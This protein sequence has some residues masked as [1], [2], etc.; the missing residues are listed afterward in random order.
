MELCA[1]IEGL[2]V[3]KE[4]CAVEIFTDSEY[5]RNGITQWIKGWKA[6][7]WRT[8]DKKPVKNEDLWRE[9]D[10]ACARHRVTWKWLKGHAGHADNERC[11]ELAGKAI[12]TIRQQHSAAD[13]KAALAV[14]KVSPEKDSACL[15]L[16]GSGPHP[17]LK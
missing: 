2:R 15:P 7:G 14:F 11:D 13:L 8:K 17:I 10:S 9:L 12:Q 16:H 6:H 4:A 3:L 5:M 1:A